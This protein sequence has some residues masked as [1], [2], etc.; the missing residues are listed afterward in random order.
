M[1]WGEVVGIEVRM[2]S[3][4]KVVEDGMEA[5]LGEGVSLMLDSE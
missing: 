5:R 4:V 2:S 3:C 1:I